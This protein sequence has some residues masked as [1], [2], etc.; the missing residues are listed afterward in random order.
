MSSPGE[1]FIYPGAYLVPFFVG[2]NLASAYALSSSLVRSER[3]MQ[4][5]DVPRVGDGDMRIYLSLEAALGARIGFAY[6]AVGSLGPLF[7]D[8]RTASL[9]F[10]GRAIVAI[11]S[12]IT[13]IGLQLL[14]GWNWRRRSI[15]PG[16]AFLK[17]VE[18]R[19][20]AGE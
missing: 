10:I 12:T 4:I 13:L 11:V 8:P 18:I 14:V 2:C 7:V 16:K 1:W 9:P 5:E 3:R 15:H 6:L 20:A 17:L 19:H